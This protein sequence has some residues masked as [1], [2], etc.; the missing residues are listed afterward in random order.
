MTSLESFP[1]EI[2]HQIVHHIVRGQIV[3]LNDEPFRGY[4]GYKE[5]N[6]IPSKDVLNFAFTSKRLKSIVYPLIF[7]N[8]G[9]LMK[10]NFR[11]LKC[12]DFSIP[13]HSF[14]NYS[15]PPKLLFSWDSS[16]VP[17]SVLENV[18]HLFVRFHEDSNGI[19]V[20][21]PSIDLINR[22]HIPGLREIT[23]PLNNAQKYDELSLQTL[24][25]ALKKYAN[26]VSLHL[27]LSLDNSYDGIPFLD[28]LDSNEMITTFQVMAPP[29]NFRESLIRQIR[30]F[31]AL[32]KLV[33]KYGN[34]GAASSDFNNMFALTSFTAEVGKYTVNLQSLKE[35]EFLV[36]FRVKDRVD[37]QL[38]PNVECLTIDL[39]NFLSNHSSPSDFDSVTHL[40][41]DLQDYTAGFSSKLPFKNLESLQIEGDLISANT[42]HF[43]KELL[44]ANPRLVNLGLYQL[45]LRYFHL[46]IPL[47]ADIQNLELEGYEKWGQVNADEPP[48]PVNLIL[49]NAPKLRTVFMPL[50]KFGSISLQSMIDS[51]SM[52]PDLATVHLDIDD[53]IES[54]SPFE[55]FSDRDTLTSLLPSHVQVSDFCYPVKVFEIESFFPTTSFLIDVE[56]LRRLLKI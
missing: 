55:L 56:K 12:F 7:K 32:E 50:H 51:I 11:L 52:N 35:V 5:W 25:E 22:K 31:T 36:K 28:L 46:F 9:T 13:R 17:V 3:D 47:L 27:I 43:L 37:W 20:P 26:P 23:I 14:L 33:F 15:T 40:E 4:V 18:Q 45:D 6:L 49:D 16:I 39:S 2:L 19:A 48:N 30:N 54:P 10:N 42:F 8:F 29:L 24:G 53:Y 21:S 44:D 34:L 38:A 41:L 1:P